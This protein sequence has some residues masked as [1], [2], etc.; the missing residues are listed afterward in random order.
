M[1]RITSD[2]CE[3][4]VAACTVRCRPA[5]AGGEISRSGGGIVRL[6]G[7]CDNGQQICSG[8]SATATG[9]RTER[10]SR[11]TISSRSR[12]LPWPMRRWQ[13]FGLDH[14][15]KYLSFILQGQR[16]VS[17][18]KQFER[19]TCRAAVR[20]VLR[21]LATTWRESQP[22]SRINAC[23]FVDGGAQLRDANSIGTC[24]YFYIPHRRRAVSNSTSTVRTSNAARIESSRIV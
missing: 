10:K 24:C 23:L 4:G 8:L 15:D 18:P 20:S 16:L 7:S 9:I 13:R 11:F 2:L 1:V 22:R 19:S 6:S 5:L 3:C 12:R 14:E 21:W 17:R